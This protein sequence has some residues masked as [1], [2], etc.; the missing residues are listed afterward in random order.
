MTKKELIEVLCVEHEMPSKKI[1]SIV[2]DLFVLITKSLENGEEVKISQFGIF[3][4]VLRKGR[5]GRNPKTGE[6]IQIP[7]KKTVTFT[8]SKDFKRNLN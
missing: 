3:K 2:N 8:L 7:D 1:E 6:T 5:K 4:P